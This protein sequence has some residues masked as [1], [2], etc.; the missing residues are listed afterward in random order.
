MQ[1]KKT[2]I[3]RKMVFYFLLVALANV[4]V[5]SE[6]LIEIKSD[7]YRA[8]VLKVAEDIKNNQQEPEHVYILLDKLSSKFVIMVGILIAVSAVVLFLFVLQIASPIQYMVN[9]AKKIAQGDLSITIKM[10]SHDEISDL[11]NLINDLTVNL[12]EIIVQLKQMYAEFEEA[13]SRFDSK[14][15]LMPEVKMHFENERKQ[16]VETIENMAMI[17]ESFT[18]FQ[19]HKM[20][21][22]PESSKV[23]ID[24]LLKN[25]VITKSQYER[26]IGFQKEKGGYIGSVLKKLEYIDDSTLVKYIE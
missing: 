16:L 13:I 23:L 20:S 10:K 22:M 24:K 3:K 17:K 11:G 19:I 5:A 4:F 1:G 26:T 18:L 21:D 7:K 2:S 12:Q 6:L 15:Y 9:E 8:E 25:G 14:M